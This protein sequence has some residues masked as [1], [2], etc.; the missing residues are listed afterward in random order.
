MDCIPVTFLED[1]SG[2]TREGYVMKWLDFG[3]DE[4]VYAL[5]LQP[6]GRIASARMDHVVVSPGWIAD[7]KWAWWK[8]GTES[9]WTK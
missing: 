1:A 9:R 2:E 7:Q 8:P 3:P 6:T 5:I 4:G